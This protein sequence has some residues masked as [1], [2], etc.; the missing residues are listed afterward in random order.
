MTRCRRQLAMISILT[1]ALLP[2]APTVALAQGRSLSLAVFGHEG[3]SIDDFARRW[4]DQIT[5]ETGI[6]FEFMHRP[7]LGDDVQLQANPAEI[8]DVIVSRSLSTLG[9][10]ELNLPFIFP[11]RR[12]F[13]TYAQ[14]KLATLEMQDFK[15]LAIAP[16]TAKVM[17]ARTEIDD[18]DTLF[19]KEFIDTGG[20]GG[21]GIYALKHNSVAVSTI[22]PNA[23]LSDG[24]SDNTVYSLP[25]ALLS[26]IADI[27]QP[28]RAVISLTNH[29][30]MGVWVGM[31]ANVLEGFLPGNAASVVRISADMVED[32]ILHEESLVKDLFRQLEDIGASVHTPENRRDFFSAFPIV[33]ASSNFCT[34]GEY[35][36]KFLGGCT[37]VI[38]DRDDEC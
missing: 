14:E 37:C 4:A 33:R 22:E 27:P 1:V 30:F 20:L 9:L 35:R 15:V 12:E 34:P 19:G 8:A 16:S 28:E 25:S 24:I 38:G 7:E 31:R 5:N 17:V 13:A 3:G 32:A 36:I 29:Q 26:R 6:H 18:S 11:S 2:L 21:A 23:V 10:G